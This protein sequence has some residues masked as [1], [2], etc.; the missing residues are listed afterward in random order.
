MRLSLS[1]IVVVLATCVLWPVGTADAPSPEGRQELFDLSAKRTKLLLELEQTD[2][3][4]AALEKT[5][6]A[7]TDRVATPTGSDYF[8]SISDTVQFATAKKDITKGELLLF[9]A[10]G[11]YRVK[12]VMPKLTTKGVCWYFRPNRDIKGQ[13]IAVA[14]FTSVGVL[15]HERLPV[16]DADLGERS[17]DKLTHR[18]R[19]PGGDDVVVGLVL[20][21][22]QPHRPHVVAGVAPVPFGVERSHHQL[23]LQSELDPSR[24][25][26][27]LPRRRTRSPGEDPRG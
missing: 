26:G 12:D 1:L 7:G 27:H 5:E 20:L 19:L 9:H 17:L 22:H 10:P 21:Q 14:W 25:I 3:R 4:I 23:V 11:I 6:F 18:V 8:E 15:A 13:Q 24:C 16:V 2:K